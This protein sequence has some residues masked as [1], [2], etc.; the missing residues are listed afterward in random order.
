[1]S[2]WLKIV[3]KGVKMAQSGG[4]MGHNTVKMAQS[5][6]KMGQNRPTSLKMAQNRPKM[7]QRRVTLSKGTETATNTPQGHSGWHRFVAC[8]DKYPQNRASPK[9]SGEPKKNRVGPWF[10]GEIGRAAFGAP[11]PISPKNYGPT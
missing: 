6:V 10:W 4:K 11:S 2:K 5:L 9:K 7:A 8:G 1:M 3:S